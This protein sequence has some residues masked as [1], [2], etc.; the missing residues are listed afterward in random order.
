MENG[1]AFENAS[2][3]ANRKQL[4]LTATVR[5]IPV[6]ILFRILQVCIHIRQL[7][8]SRWAFP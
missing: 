5:S 2:R 8:N 1:D 7:S 6:G 4:R 3:N